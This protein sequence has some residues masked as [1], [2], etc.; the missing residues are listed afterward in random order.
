MTFRCGLA[1]MCVRYAAKCI[2]HPSFFS[3]LTARAAKGEV[4][5]IGE[6]FGQDMAEQRGLGVP[7][8]GAPLERA[9]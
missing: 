5:P 4:M 2:V 3:F 7:D 9:A 6:H 8:A 1:V